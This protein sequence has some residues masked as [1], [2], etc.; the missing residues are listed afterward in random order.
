MCKNIKELLRGK[1]LLSELEDCRDEEE[2][3]ALL[4]HENLW[5]RVVDYPELEALK[6][7]YE[8]GEIEADGILSLSQ[9]DKVAGGAKG[10][11]KNKTKSHNKR[12]EV[13]KKQQNKDTVVPEGVE[14]IVEDTGEES[15]YAESGRNADKPVVEELPVEVPK[16]PEDDVV[17]HIKEE[18]SPVR[19]D[20]SSNPAIDIVEKEEDHKKNGVKE[21]AAK[22][23]EDDVV[24]PAEEEESVAELKGPEDN[25]ADPAV[26]VVPVLVKE[27]KEK[28]ATEE[29]D[30]E[31]SEEV[32]GEDESEFVEEK[33][34]EPV[35]E[36]QE[37]TAEDEK[38]DRMIDEEELENMGDGLNSAGEESEE[39]VVIS[40]EMYDLVEEQLYRLN[41]LNENECRRIVI[42][43]ANE[44][45][46]SGKIEGLLTLL[47]LTSQVERTPYWQAV[48]VGN[49]GFRIELLEENKHNILEYIEEKTFKTVCKTLQMVMKEYSYKFDNDVQIY[50]VMR[51]IIMYSENQI[52]SFL[53]SFDKIRVFP[54][55]SFRG[56]RLGETLYLGKYAAHRIRSLMLT[57]IEDIKKPGSEH[58]KFLMGL[59]N[60][61][62]EDNINSDQELFRAFYSYAGIYENGELEDSEITAKSILSEIFMYVF[63]SK[64]PCNPD[65]VNAIFSTLEKLPIET[66][67]RRIKFILDVNIEVNGTSLNYDENSKTLTLPE[68]GFRAWDIL[69]ICV[70]LDRGR[71]KAKHVSHIFSKLPS[72][73]Y[74]MISEVVEIPGRGLGKEY[75]VYN[76]REGKLYSTDGFKANDEIGRI[77]V[78][79]N[80]QGENENVI[81]V[82][83]SNGEISDLAD[84][85]NNGL[86]RL[87][88][89][90]HLENILELGEN[91]FM[92]RRGDIIDNWLGKA[93]GKSLS[94]ENVVEILLNHILG[95]EN[96]FFRRGAIFAFL[97][98]EKVVIRA[99]KEGEWAIGWH[100]SGRNTVEYMTLNITTV[101]HEI[102]HHLD[103]M[104]GMISDR[105]YFT[106]T[107]SFKELAEKDMLRY[108]DKDK[109]VIGEVYRKLLDVILKSNIKFGFKYLDLIGCALKSIG[110]EHPLLKYVHGGAEYDLIVELPAIVFSVFSLLDP[111]KIDEELMQILYEL[112]DLLPNSIRVMMQNLFGVDITRILYTGYEI[113]PEKR[114]AFEISTSQKDNPNFD[115]NLSE[116]EEAVLAQS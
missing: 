65:E 17:E 6:E 54:E 78:Y 80:Y 9:L 7:S 37:E 23:P 13:W 61:F 16:L 25:T 42:E 58:K 18:K 35:E 31:K 1:G 81:Y 40:E 95:I 91:L 32:F 97:N 94:R 102:F 103:E 106:H 85:R 3:V 2:V 69:H 50:D 72:E 24:E 63:Y 86:Q 53:E 44:C 26:E 68:T 83:D 87:I 79:E 21:E 60:K 62:F 48:S 104:H 39:E 73:K 111:Q 108:V 99:R 109:K 110:A 77:I 30:D 20:E 89:G 92:T 88:V 96:Y 51:Y 5:G 8:N 29:I 59:D 57:Q 70:L 47:K 100:L 75:A 10:G 36:K 52:K 14:H 64:M 49:D 12:L 115:V 33:A 45:A 11:R 22:L 4:K 76:P 38:T 19:A 56:I 66:L 90:E 82:V 113:E 114:K 34:V 93:V 105:H 46:D 27:S 43:L 67:A 98:L 71:C 74:F 15:R 84:R 28:S 101:I 112:V 116:E 107:P 41:V 55:W